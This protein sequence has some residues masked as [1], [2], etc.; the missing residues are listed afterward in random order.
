MPAISAHGR[1]YDYGQGL[2]TGLTI[3]DV[4]DWPDILS[5]VTAEDVTAAARELLNSKAVVT[6]WLLPAD[7][8]TAEAQPVRAEEIARPPGRPDRAA[9]TN[10]V[11]K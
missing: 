9:E 1:A 4:N 8:E 11:Q 5:Q 2:A 7:P 3:E 6:G 10:E